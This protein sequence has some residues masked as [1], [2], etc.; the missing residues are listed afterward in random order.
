MA[1]ELDKEREWA[2]HMPSQGENPEHAMRQRTPQGVEEKI[3]SPE[4]RDAASAAPERADPQAV[5]RNRE[6]VED[7]A[8][9]YDEAEEKFAERN[10]G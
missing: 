8:M 3:S 9:R 10:K 4:S 2:E 1:K 7:D 6:F 5:R